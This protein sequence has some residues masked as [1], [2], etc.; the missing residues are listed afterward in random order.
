[1]KILLPIL[2]AFFCLSVSAEKIEYEIHDKS[3]GKLIGAGVKVYSLDDII[4]NFY[5]SNGRQ[6]IEKHVELY[7][8]YKI[9]ARIF[10]ENQ[11]TG[12]GL[13]AQKTGADF[14]W[15]WCPS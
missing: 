11:L 7:Q 3:T 5:T 2:L 12:F 6:V 10:R 13:V 8:G 14:S 15:G 9:G 1:M 4:T